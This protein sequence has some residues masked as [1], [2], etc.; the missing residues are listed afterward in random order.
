MVGM[1]RTL[2]PETRSL[3]ANS[4]RHF[5]AC[6][7]VVLNG[8]FVSSQ[9]TAGVADAPYAYRSSAFTRLIDDSGKYVI[10]DNASKFYAWFESAYASNAA[11]HPKDASRLSLV[12]ALE[13]R[14]AQIAALSGEKRTKLET[15]TAAWLHR[16]VKTLIPTFSL[17]RGFEFSYTVSRGERQCLLQSVLI[18][19][20]LQ[21]AGVNAGLA[22]V[23]RNPAG[24]E[25][26]LGHAATLIR[27]PN[28]DIVVD[29]SEPQPFATHQGLF[30]L[31][32]TTGSYRFVVPSYALDS[33]I[34]AYTTPDGQPVTVAGTRSLDYN[35]V[36]SQFYFYR[37]ERATNGFLAK[38]GTPEGLE[39]SASALEAAIKI[40]PRNPLAVYVLGH[41]Y[42]RLGKTDQA[43]AQY[44]QGY[45]LYQTFGYVPTGALD[46]YHQ[47]VEK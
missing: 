36:R 46:A 19:G 15:D 3:K 39:A 16:T 25:S 8:V 12:R 26:N 32:A 23:W 38:P 7:L 42:R 40:Q 29:A 21:R 33:S 18:A 5:L 41:V 28:K 43:R 11:T 35:F 9:V 34:T 37:G 22:M 44:A 47:Y 4:R 30:V 24:V 6:A 2:M 13:K 14:R 17:D 45:Q 10:T 20:M 27:L 31:D 1:M